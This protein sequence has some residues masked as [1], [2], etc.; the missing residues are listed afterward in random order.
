MSPWPW[1]S[2]LHSTSAGHK[3]YDQRNRSQ[4]LI[5]CLR[6]ILSEGHDS[7]LH[8]RYPAWCVRSRARSRYPRGNAACWHA[9]CR[10]KTRRPEMRSSK[11]H[12]S[13]WAGREKCPDVT[14]RSA[15]EVVEGGALPRTSDSSTG[16]GI[17]MPSAMRVAGW[18]VCG[19]RATL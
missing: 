9:R 5:K 3:V 19:I 8:R 14:H 1:A 16:Q 7:A 18:L 4:G 12:G 10:N 11:T 15:R 6:R 2:R 17:P 13:V